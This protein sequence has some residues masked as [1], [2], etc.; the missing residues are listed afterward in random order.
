MTSIQTQLHA[1]LL[2]GAAS[3]FAAQAQAQAPLRL[4]QQPD[5]PRTSTGAARQQEFLRRIHYPLQM[6][7]GAQQLRWQAAHQALRP[8]NTETGSGQ[9]RDGE[10]RPWQSD[11]PNGVKVAGEELFYSGRIRDV[12]V[13]ATGLVRIGAATGGIWERNPD[14][15]WRPLSDSITSQAIGTFATQ[16]GNDNVLVVGTGEAWQR[17]GTGVWRTDNGGSTWQHISLEPE[18][19]TCRTLRFD[20]TDSSVVHLAAAEGYYRSTDGGRSFTRIL[21]G[22]YDDVVIDPADGQRVFVSK[23]YEGLLRSLSGGDSLSWNPLPGPWDASVFGRGV[24][25]I[26]ALDPDILYFNLIRSDTWRTEGVYKSTDGGN[27]WIRCNVQNPDL[28]AVSDFH[29]GQGWYNTLIAVRPDDCDQAWVGG[30]SLWRATD[31]FTFK[32]I[33]PL[34]VDQHRMT[35]APNGSGA[36]LANDGGIFYSPDGWFWQ[37]GGATNNLPIRQYSSFSIGVSDT[38]TMAGGS[39]DNG[40]AVRQGWWG[41]WQF[42]IGGDGGAVAISRYDHTRIFATNGVYGG[43]LSF[44]QLE[45]PNEGISWQDV[46]NG[47]NPCGQWWLNVRDNEAGNVYTHCGGDVYY[48]DFFD[49]TWTQ[50]NAGSPFFATDVWNL[51]V[52][53]GLPENVYACLP[54]WASRRVMVLDRST[55]SWVDRSS[56]LPGDTYVREVTP[57]AAKPDRAFALMGGVASSGDLGRKIFRTDDAGRTWIN[58]SG[59]LPNVPLTDLLL[60]PVD[61]NKLYACGEVGCFHT[62]D[63]GATWVDWSEGLPRHLL[64][65][66]MGLADS[67]AI[68]G[69]LWLYAATYGR[70]MWKRLIQEDPPVVSGEGFAGAEQLLFGPNPASDLIQGSMPAFGLNLPSELL[71]FSTDGRCVMRQGLSPG[72]TSWQMSLPADLAS[73]LYQVMLRNR[74]GMAQGRLL[75]SR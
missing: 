63:G 50:I 66:E 33:N 17:D 56:G 41:E 67:L 53:A 37:G 18:V 57:D 30:G 7:N 20:A 44:R 74:Q 48:R 24:L 26:C 25:A 12:E 71:L 38:R 10:E 59:N 34:H 28:S 3:L 61:S 9:L 40:L 27:S 13:T 58:A 23:R 65:T 32:E 46:N 55:G 29:W 73:G 31:G 42:T 51:T 36:W 15:T 16:P 1:A 49:D 19:S 6:P 52:G 2:L 35:W 54:P 22:E 64:V 11:G 4:D 45:S 60:H 68:N 43:S 70:A 8:T 47:I 39:Q 5:A 72:N 62:E 21:D 14:N 69:R 75:I